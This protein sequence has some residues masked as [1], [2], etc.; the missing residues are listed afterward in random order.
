MI[1]DINITDF[2]GNSISCK[3]NFQF[4]LVQLKNPITYLTRLDNQE[5]REYIPDYDKL[6]RSIKEKYNFNRNNY[7]IYKIL[8]SRTKADN[9]SIWEVN[10][11]RIREYTKSSLGVDLSMYESLGDLWFPTSVIT[12]PITVLLGNRS[13]GLLFC[14]TSYVFVARY[15]NGSLWKPVSENKSCE[16]VSF[17]FSIKDKITK[18]YMLRKDI[19]IPYEGGYHTVDNITN[20][21]EFNLVST[22]DTRKLTVNRTKFV[23]EQPD[24]RLKTRYNDKYLSNLGDKLALTDIS[25][26]KSQQLS[27]TSQGELKID[28]KCLSIPTDATRKNGFVYANDCNNSLGQKWFPFN[29]HFISQYDKSCLSADNDNLTSRSCVENN[30]AQLWETD[31]RDDSEITETSKTEDEQYVN[32]RNRDVEEPGPEYHRK[33]YDK[34]G[35]HVV[36]VESDN[37]W[38]LGDDKLQHTHDMNRHRSDNVSTVLRNKDLYELNDKEY[39]PSDFDS[40]ISL[41]MD[42]QFTGYG[43]GYSFADRQLKP[44]GCNKK[45]KHD[46]LNNRY[47]LFNKP[48]LEEDATSDSEEDVVSDKNNSLVK[49][50][51]GTSAYTSDKRMIC[52]KWN[53]QHEN[54]EGDYCYEVTPNSTKTNET[55]A[56]PVEMKELK[57][58]VGTEGVCKEGVTSEG[59]KKYECIRQT[60][61]SLVGGGSSRLDSQLVATAESEDRYD[62]SSNNILILSIL[63]FLFLLCIYLYRKRVR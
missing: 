16:A 7:D 52:G 34:K 57:D 24:F 44:C 47:N 32:S 14:P 49:E 46:V 60:V 38:Y 53:C 22:T 10:I 36:L 20:A 37:P 9:D 23:K 50:C 33:W 54:T 31:M 59:K 55:N 4:V 39:G 29:N 15:K 1:K 43:L 63:L 25:S 18:G 30:A 21:N 62:D 42:R 19:I 48:I 8:S 51:N 61:K 40:H 35:R 5:N 41:D 12:N 3:P 17:M 13:S 6:D 2:F 26:K 58:K 45:C 28:G 11:D 27:Y 56:A